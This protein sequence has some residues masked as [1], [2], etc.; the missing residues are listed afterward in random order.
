M[1]GRSCSVRFYVI[2]THI[3]IDKCCQGV[4]E[5]W[6][7]TRVDYPDKWR[8]DSLRDLRAEFQSRALDHKGMIMFPNIIKV[9]SVAKRERYQ[10]RLTF[11]IENHA[12]NIIVI[13]AFL[14]L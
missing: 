13:F 12:V 3:L 6:K 4:P 8:F 5:N 7:C 11:A 1:C 9:G 10:D 2:W 14:E